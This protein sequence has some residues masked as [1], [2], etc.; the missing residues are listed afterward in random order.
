MKVLSC[1]NEIARWRRTQVIKESY[2]SFSKRMAPWRDYASKAAAT[3]L[4]TTVASVC[5]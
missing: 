4:P 1:D 3:C 5:I 2:T